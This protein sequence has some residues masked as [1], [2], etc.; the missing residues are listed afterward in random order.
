MKSFYKLS[1]P[2]PCHEDW[3]EMAPNE[4][5]RFCK[6]CTKT[7]VDFTKMNTNQ[8]QDYISKNK[9]QGICGHI[10]QTQL[11]TINIQISESVFNQSLSFNKLFLLALL[12]TMGTSLFSCS[13]GKG[14]L[15]KIES[16]EI[17]TRKVD[18]I[19]VKND[20]IK[21]SLYN[22]SD[23]IEKI[24]KPITKPQTAPVLTGKVIEVV[25]GLMQIEPIGEPY[26]CMT[27]ENL[28]KFINTP[29]GLTKEEER[30]YLNHKISKIVKKEFDTLVAKKPN[31]KGRQRIYIQFEINKKGKIENIKTRAPHQFLEDEAKRVLSL[32]PKFIPAKHN[33]KNV[34]II[35]NLPITFK[36]ED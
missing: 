16:V 15:K 32:F 33:G 21:D 3:S 26:Y 19:I 34:S 17:I 4:K 9:H 23:E 35:Y 22:E 5:G 28:P 14:N 30:K 31:L 20:T 36:V 18:S 10:K 29:K 12:I 24:Q 25:D 8:I 27:V 1:I 13:D 11:D 6:S 7:V 2:K